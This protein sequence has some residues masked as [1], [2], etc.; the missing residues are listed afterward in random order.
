MKMEMRVFAQKARV[1]QMISPGANAVPEYLLNTRPAAIQ[2]IEINNRYRAYCRTF[3][4]MMIYLMKSLTAVYIAAK[5][6]N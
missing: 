3:F 1:S 6:P 4:T 2:I 5:T